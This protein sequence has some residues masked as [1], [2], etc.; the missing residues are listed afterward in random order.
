V[1]DSS[2]I[3]RVNEHPQITQDCSVIYKEATIVNGNDIRAA[4][5][6]GALTAHTPL[7]VE[8]VRRAF[9]ALF[10]SLETPDEVLDYCTELD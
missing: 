3:I 5:A 8:I 7:A 4:I 10:A 6:N 1:I 2:C 9:D